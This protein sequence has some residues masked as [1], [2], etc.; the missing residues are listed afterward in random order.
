MLEQLPETRR[1][2]YQ[3][4]ILRERY[5]ALLIANG[6]PPS[7]RLLRALLPRADRVIALDGGVNTLHRLRVKPSHVVG[8]LD[9][10]QDSALA[11]ARRQGASIIPRP[12]ADEPD[13]AKGLAYCRRRGWTQVIVAGAAGDRVDHLLAAVSCAF[14]A[15]RMQAHFIT[16]EM[17]ILPLRGRASGT[18]PV[19]PGH[20]ISWTGFPEA[21][22]C[23][24]TGVR[25]PFTRRLL[26]L[27]GFR[28]LSN[29]PE[30]PLVG[31]RQERGQS[32][33]MVGLKPV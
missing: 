16:N 2:A 5:D 19:P 20:I 12:A 25:W 1:H 3:L 28:S 4:T 23:T 18:L 17:A 29:L 22:P 9:S 6:E 7:A 14:Q 10:A 15:A 30:S 33:L 11:W 31:Y 8:D 27:N 24:L 26:K 13:I 21:G 32:L